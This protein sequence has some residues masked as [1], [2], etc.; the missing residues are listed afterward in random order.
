MSFAY[1]EG[2]AI[3]HGAVNL[4]LGRKALECIRVALD[5]EPVQIAIND[6][7]ID[8]TGAVTKAEFVEHQSVRVAVVFF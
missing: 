7:D 4:Y 2:G 3:E 8:A 6:G 1:N 5:L